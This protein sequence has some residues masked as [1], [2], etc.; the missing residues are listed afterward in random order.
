[1]TEPARQRSK[2]DYE[3]RIGRY[4][5][6]LALAFMRAAGVHAGQR[7]LDVGLW[8]RRADPTAG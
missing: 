4:G 8:W 2:P 1:M 5:P 7:A 6:E 3:G